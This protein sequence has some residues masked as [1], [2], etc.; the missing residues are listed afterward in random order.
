MSELKDRLTAHRNDAL[1]LLGQVSRT[2]QL[3]S[4]FRLAGAVSHIARAQVLLAEELE[5]LVGVSKPGGD[6]SIT[7]SGEGEEEST[8]VNGI[9]LKRS[10]EAPED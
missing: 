4:G 3:H 10:L 7:E 9:R 6:S 8:P 1:A 2:A 5:S